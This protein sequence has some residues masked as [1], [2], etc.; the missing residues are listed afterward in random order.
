MGNFSIN[1]KL[2]STIN[3][4]NIKMANK[5]H[6]HGMSRD[7]LVKW[8]LP[9]ILGLSTFS[10]FMFGMMETYH[11]NY[12]ANKFRYDN[13]HEHKFRGLQPPY[14]TNYSRQLYKSKDPTL[15]IDW[16]SFREDVQ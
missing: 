4:N 10:F 15:K 9:F 7:L 11:F 6:F 1:K 3:T 13:Y 8:K 16:H 5:M 14:M 2:Q 12:N